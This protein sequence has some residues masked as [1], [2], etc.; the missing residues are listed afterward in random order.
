MNN[1]DTTGEF[2]FTI[3]V[4]AESA[5]DFLD[6]QINKIRVDVYIKPTNS[7]T[8]VLLST[9]CRK[10]N[11]NNIIESIALRPRRICDS[12]VNFAMLSDKYQN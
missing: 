2:K 9:C 3:S 5:L 12:D 10:R 11:K 8:Y 1:I 6:F 4:A 7:F